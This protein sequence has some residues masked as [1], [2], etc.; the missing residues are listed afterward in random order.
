LAFWPKNYPTGI[1]SVVVYDLV[2]SK[3]PP[4]KTVDPV[5][6]TINV[7]QKNVGYFQQVTGTIGLLQTSRPYYFQISAPTAGDVGT[8]AV[9]AQKTVSRDPVSTVHAKR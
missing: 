8:S 2:D 3:N 6:Y 9:K 7:Y 4:A 1:Y 5:S